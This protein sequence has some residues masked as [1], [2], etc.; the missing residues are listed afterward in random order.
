MGSLA[1]HY[2]VSHTAMPLNSHATHGLEA[3]I[4]ADPCF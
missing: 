3:V 4:N 1:Y 2:Q